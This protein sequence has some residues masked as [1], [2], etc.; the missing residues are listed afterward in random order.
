[1]LRF[2]A[3]TERAMPESSTPNLKLGRL[4]S[5]AQ[6][7]PMGGQGVEPHLS[8]GKLNIKTWPLLVDMLICTV[9]FF[10]LLFLAFFGVFS[11]FN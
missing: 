2:S 11:I 3:S 6:L 8:P 5:V 7:M 1:M 9:V 10:N 4:G